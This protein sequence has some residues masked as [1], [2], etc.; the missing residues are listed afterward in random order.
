MALVSE[1][2]YGYGA[3]AFEAYIKENNGEIELD[4]KEVVDQ[5][6]DKAR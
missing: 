2:E 5:K 4:M 1:K 3:D 6:N